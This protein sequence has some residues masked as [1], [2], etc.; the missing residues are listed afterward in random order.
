MKGT[1]LDLILICVFV[2]VLGFA[3][4]IGYVV[5]QGFQAAPP[6]AANPTAA[7]AVASGLSTLALIGNSALFVIMAFGILSIISAYYTE[8]NGVF[9]IFSILTFSITIML[10]SIFSGVFVDLAASSTLAPIASQFYM[11]IQ[12]MQGFPTY[13]LLVG[14]LILVALYVK[15]NSPT[16]TLGPGGGT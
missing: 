10:V 8:T 6:I 4:M 12:V 5:L 14:A 2:V 7:A 3:A 1:V 15:Q 13:A 16:G 9:F 11:L